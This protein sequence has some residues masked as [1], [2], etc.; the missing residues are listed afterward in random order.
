MTQL[1]EQVSTF[2]QIKPYQHVF[3]DGWYG[4]DR[5]MFMQESFCLSDI[6]HIT[7]V[8]FRGP[9]FYTFQLTLNIGLELRDLEF[10]FKTKGLATKAQRELTRAWA[11]VGEF[12]YE[13]DSTGDPKGSEV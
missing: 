3:D 5:V 9:T 13:G 6:R 7:P 10:E 2:F 8:M 1:H 12:A 11:R 4:H